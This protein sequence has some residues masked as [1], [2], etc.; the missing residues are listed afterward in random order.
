MVFL[1]AYLKD[2]PTLKRFL[3]TALHLGLSKKDIINT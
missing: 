3:D 1:F 2:T